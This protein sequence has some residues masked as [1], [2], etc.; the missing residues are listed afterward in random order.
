MQF[1]LIDRIVELE[2]GRQLTAVKVLSLAEEYL[3]D[4][5]PRFPVMPG[6]LMLESLFQASAWLLLKT[7]DFARPLVTLEEARNIKYADFVSPGEV[8]EVTV[9][10][11]KQREDGLTT[12]K[13]RGLI[14]ETTALSGKLVVRQKRLADERSDRETTDARMRRM[15]RQQFELLYRP[16]SAEVVAG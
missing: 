16:K 8:L 13:T 11:A 1:T 4:H 5:F 12:L 6:V 7:D 9:E 14:G 2:E 15:L 3:Q 10:L